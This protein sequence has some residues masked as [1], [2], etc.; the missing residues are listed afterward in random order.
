[1]DHTED[2]DNDIDIFKPISR[3]HFDKF[4]K[5]ITEEE[6]NSEQDTVQLDFDDGALLAERGSLA[7]LSMETMVVYE[8][9]DQSSEMVDGM[10]EATESPDS[11]MTTDN[12]F[13]QLLKPPS[14]NTHIFKEPIMI[15]PAVSPKRDKKKPLLISSISEEEEE[16]EDTIAPLPN[17]QSSNLSRNVTENR[18]KLD[19]RE[20]PEMKRKKHD[21]SPVNKYTTPS[22]DQRSPASIDQGSPLTDQGSPSSFP[23]TTS[24]VRSFAMV[25]QMYET[26]NS[27]K[28][29][30]AGFTR[31]AGQKRN[32]PVYSPLMIVATA[33]PRVSLT[34]VQEEEST[35]SKDIK[36][37]TNDIPI[38]VEPPNDSDDTTRISLTL[39]QEVAFDNLEKL[40]ESLNDSD[41]T[42]ENL[43]VEENIAK[44][45]EAMRS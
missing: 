40:K 37:E 3:T 15:K 34:S 45:K 4:G 26:S 33:S 11:H 42:E 38:I 28:L 8:D 23:P 12:A 39:S 44:R 22:T 36:D 43:T 16:D 20:S 7:S 1:M 35:L 6:E 9:D 21:N 31:V 2:E 13:Q 18:F 14:D 27:T 19:G 29:E 10:K 17:I 24:V 32:T 25:K 41:K 5:L 30:N